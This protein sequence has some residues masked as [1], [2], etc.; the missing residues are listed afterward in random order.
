M[1]NNMP[2]EQPIASAAAL[3]PD[4]RTVAESRRAVMLIG[5]GSLRPDAGAAMIRLAARAEVAGVAPMVVAGF[6][7]DRRPTFAE[8]LARCIHMGAGAVIVQPYFLGPGR[9]IHE[10]LAQ[11]V[12]AARL[13]HPG[14]VL[15]TAQPFGSHPALA[16]LV[17][18]RALEADYLA[19]NPHIAIA[20]S[21]R[22]LDDGA[23]WQPLHMR[24]RTGLLI[25]AHGSA[26]AQANRP[27]YQIARQVRA[28]RRYAATTV[29]FLERSKPGIPE[30]AAAMAQRGIDQIIA[31]PYFLHAGK[32]VCVDL[33]M[34]I[35]AARMY[36]RHGTII[37]A[38]HL[39]Y[40]RLLVPVIADRVAEMWRANAPG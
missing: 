7:N 6:L 40:D 33:P 27:V 2:R 38:E 31:V 26:N 4:L 10:D 12:E 11:L 35:E 14:L 18:K 16:R 36:T 17:L 13:A 34:Q 28:S 25:M 5:H 32:H 22:A 30:A 23:G 15:R 24:Q 8:A 20:G 3:T 21:P 9:L 39:G 19:A 29:C 1:M 37:L